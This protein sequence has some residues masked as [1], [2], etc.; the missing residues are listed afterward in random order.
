MPVKG[1]G[2]VARAFHSPLCLEEIVFRD[3]EPNELLVQ[4]ECLRSMPYGFARDRW[5]VA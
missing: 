3:P 1:L 5:R 4:V 2:A